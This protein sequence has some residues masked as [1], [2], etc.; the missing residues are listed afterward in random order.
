MRSVCPHIVPAWERPAHLV[1]AILPS[2]DVASPKYAHCPGLGGLTE[3]G[4]RG[5][6]KPRRCAGWAAHRPCLGELQLCGRRNGP[7]SAQDPALGENCPFGRRRAP[8]FSQ[9][10]GLYLLADS[11]KPGPCAPVFL[12]S[13]DVVQESPASAART[14]RS[15]PS[16]DFAQGRRRIVP[17]WEGP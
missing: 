9:V 5:S 6:P 15:L 8:T 17:T 10:S 4:C 2:R 1:A 3:C 7:M 13:R 11:P 16:R 12:P 14:L